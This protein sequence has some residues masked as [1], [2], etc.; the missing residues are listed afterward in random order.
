MSMNIFA[1]IDLE[2]EINEKR[3]GLTKCYLAEQGINPNLVSDDD[4]LA[5][6]SCLVT[7][8]KK[9]ISKKIKELV[10]TTTE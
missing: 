1:V 4:M 5:I 9:K 6:Y 10:L 8:A 3:I 7:K 2:K